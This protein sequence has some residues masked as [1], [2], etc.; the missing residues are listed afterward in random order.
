MSTTCRSPAAEPMSRF[1]IN[2]RTKL[3]LIQLILSVISGLTLTFDNNICT[4]KLI[5]V[6]IGGLKMI[7][8]NVNYPLS[9]KD[10]K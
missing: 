1:Q 8:G 10:L 6:Q 2:L 4:K 7:Y 3:A 9:A 5:L